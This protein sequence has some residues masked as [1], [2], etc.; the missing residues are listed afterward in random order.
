MAF[1]HDGTKLII[2]VYLF[3][4]QNIVDLTVKYHD[5]YKLKHEG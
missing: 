3:V 2:S 4:I 1:I 5:G